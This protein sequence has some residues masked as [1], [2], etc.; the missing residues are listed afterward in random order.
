[1]AI[2]FNKGRRPYELIA[3]QFSCHTIHEDGRFEHHEWINSEPGVFPNFDFLVAFKDVLDK[4]NGTIFRYAAHENTVLQKI[5]AQL[6]NEMQSGEKSIPA[7]SEALVGWIKSLTEWD[8]TVPVGGKVKTRRVCGE[9][10]MVDMCDL[11]KEFYYHPWMRGSNSIKAVLPAILSTSGFLKERYSKRYTSNNFENFVWWQ[12]DASTRLPIDPY[13]LLPPLFEDVD[14]SK[15]SILLENEHIEE[16]GVAMLAYAKMQFSEM[17]EEERHAI[18]RG[19]LKYCELDTLAM[20]MIFEH[21]NY[22]KG[23]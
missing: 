16:G 23:N 15:D 17:T 5:L 4:D 19:L 12:P 14:I 3:F 10:N 22:L 18:I 11:V 9:R 20:A 8:E 1:M 7:N 2:P 13:S 21:W 6:Q